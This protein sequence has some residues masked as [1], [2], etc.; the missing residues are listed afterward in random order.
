MLQKSK[1]NASKTKPKSNLRPSKCLVL[2][3]VNCVF[4]FFGSGKGRFWDIWAEA[5]C[6]KP[7][8]ICF[9]SKIIC[10]KSHKICFDS[11]IICFNSKKYAPLKC[12]ML[13]LPK[14]YASQKSNMLRLRK[15]YASTINN[16]LRNK[17][18]CFDY[19]KICSMFKQYASN[20]KNICF[21]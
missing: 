6:F 4:A 8:P 5:T 20:T 11:K 9:K 3:F 16:M 1:H 21:N 13:R 7:K 12:N 17:I 15:I 19:E 2:L 10:F 18:I 14:K